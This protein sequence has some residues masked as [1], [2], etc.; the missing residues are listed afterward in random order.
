MKT[1]LGRGER[2]AAP[3]YA[4]NPFGFGLVVLG[5]AVAVVGT[6]LPRA[7]STAL[8]LSGIQH[9]TLLQSGYG[10]GIIIG[11]VIL[12]ADSRPSPGVPLGSRSRT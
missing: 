11:A 6:F 2:E 10:V 4:I 1:I 7:E 5:A 8:T 12:A 9:N 3:R